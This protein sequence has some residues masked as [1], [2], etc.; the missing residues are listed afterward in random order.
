MNDDAYTSFGICS[1]CRCRILY[2]PVRMP[3]SAPIPNPDKPLHY[4]I[5]YVDMCIPCAQDA[6]TELHQDLLN[7]SLSP[8]NVWSQSA[9]GT[10]HIVSITTP[11]PVLDKEEPAKLGWFK[12][13][14]RYLW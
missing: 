3:V 14:I 8:H 2:S 9:D 13:F 10:L 1:G 5:E 7:G 4:G 11:Q 12:R 6:L